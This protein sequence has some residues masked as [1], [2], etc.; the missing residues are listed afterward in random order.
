MWAALRWIGR[1]AWNVV[2]WAV[3]NLW[4]PILLYTSTRVVS[5]WLIEEEPFVGARV[6]GYLV[7]GA[8]Y[9]GTT[10]LTISTLKALAAKRVQEILAPALLP[11]L[12]QPEAWL[13]GYRFG[14]P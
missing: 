8:G 13:G 9:I 4:K 11:Q 5:R 3:V 2:K 12:W 14:L 7:S 6:L 1:V 10:W